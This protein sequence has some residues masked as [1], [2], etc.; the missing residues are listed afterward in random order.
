MSKIIYDEITG[1]VTALFQC[2]DPEREQILL[3]L[4]TPPGHAV[5]DAPG[6]QSPNEIA[7]DTTGKDHKIKKKP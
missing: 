3:K 7:I 4:N 6:I 5:M 1:E 2:D